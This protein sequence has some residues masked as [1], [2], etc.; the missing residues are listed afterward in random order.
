MSI[1]ILSLL[2]TGTYMW[3][4]SALFT[5]GLTHTRIF[6]LITYSRRGGIGALSLKMT[7]L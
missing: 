1:G 3:L 6:L 4:L 2:F 7:Y 5:F